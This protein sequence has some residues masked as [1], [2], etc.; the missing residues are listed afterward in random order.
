VA[1]FVG[2]TNFFSGEVVGFED[3][4]VTVKCASGQ[5]LAGSQTKG[6]Q[7]L[8]NGGNACVAV[9]PEMIAIAAV[10][11]VNNSTNIAIRGQVMNRIFLGEHSEY[12]VATEGYG[13][14]M[15]LSPKSIE[16]N[17][18]SFAPGDSVSISWKPEAALILGDT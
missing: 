17:S 11:E 6:A 10:D 1:D 7:R 18:R 3:S 14:V 9:R 8:A 2:K 12:L 13:E 16:S 5:I 15:V 4:R